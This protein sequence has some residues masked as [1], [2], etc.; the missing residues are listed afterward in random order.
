MADMLV[1]PVEDTDPNADWIK[2]LPGYDD[3]EV[4]EA[5]AALLAQEEEA[6]EGEEGETS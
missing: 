2:L 1:V 5:A 3:V 6:G 4:S